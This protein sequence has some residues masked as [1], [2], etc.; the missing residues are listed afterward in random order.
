MNKD[1]QIRLRYM[2]DAAHEAVTFIRDE[3]RESLDKD[4]KLLLALVKDIEIIGEA[5]SRISESRQQT[6]PGIPWAQ[7]VGMRNRLIHAYF[8]IDRETVWKT[9]TEDLPPLIAAL[10]RIVPPEENT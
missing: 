1:D 3:T 10:E 6:T 8:N 7:I 4:R 5:A 2:L 9:I